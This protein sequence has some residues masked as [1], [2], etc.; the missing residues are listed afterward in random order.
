MRLA[1][2]L[3][4]D[5]GHG[6]PPPFAVRHAERASGRRRTEVRHAG[7]AAS[8]LHGC[9][10]EPSSRKTRPAS[11][12]GHW[13]RS[14]GSDRGIR[15]R[16]GSGPCDAGR[17]GGHGLDRY[18]GAGRVRAR[19]ARPRQARADATSL[20]HGAHVRPRRRD[21]SPTG[22]HGVC[23]NAPFPAD[24]SGCCGRTSHRASAALRCGS[25]ARVAERLFRV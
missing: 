17:P 16:C 20:D 13:S 8:A 9:A 12:C 7:S 2:G 4:A 10:P 11:R 3:L 24:E 25:G 14:G 23:R 6:Q 18:G 22:N 1:Q 21:P 5:V 15:L 19:G